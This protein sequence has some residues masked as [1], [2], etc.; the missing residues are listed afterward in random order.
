M[1][2][3][4]QLQ[5]FLC[6]SSNSVQSSDPKATLRLPLFRPPNYSM[7]AFSPIMRVDVAR[8]QISVSNADHTE[9]IQRSEAHR[10]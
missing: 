9:S 7:S 1:I 5:H 4:S 2:F 6:T 10:R 8:C 3:Q